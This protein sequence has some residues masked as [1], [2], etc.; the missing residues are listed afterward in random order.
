MISRFAA[1]VQTCTF[2]FSKQ[3]VDLQSTAV[4][5]EVIAFLVFIALETS[6]ERQQEEG[7]TIAI[8]KGMNPDEWGLI[9]SSLI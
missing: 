5:S 6:K 3:I 2:C 1:F 4:T 7:T 9:P 8:E